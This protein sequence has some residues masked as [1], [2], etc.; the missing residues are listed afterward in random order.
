[1]HPDPSARQ[2]ALITALALLVVY[3]ITA[4]PALTFWDASEFAAAI[5]T[6]GIPHPPGTP[7]YVALGSTLW[8]LAPG[9]TPV[10]AGTLLS[11][12]ATASACGL[13][14]WIAA[15]CT[16]DRPAAVVAGLCAGLMGT[17]WMN[18]TETEVYAVSLLSV[19]LQ[20]S[21]AWRA[22]QH[23]DDRARML[24]IYLAA[25]SLPLHLSALVATPAAMLLACTDRDGRVR[26]NALS[27]GGL[28]ILAT[29]LL[30]RAAYW[31]ALVSIGAAVVITRGP[32]VTRRH[33]ASSVPPFRRRLAW[34]RPAALLTLLGWSAIA[35]LLVRARHSP[36]L[37]QGD[38][39]TVAKLF[40]VITRAQYD[41]AGIWPRRA[42]PWIQ[43]GNIGQYADWQVALSLWN[44]VT[45]S[46]WRTPFTVVAGCLGVV[47]AQSHW[48][49]HPVTA[50]AAL[51]LALLATLGVCTQLNLYAGPSY[52]AGVLPIDALHEARERDYFYAL[53]F[54][55]WG[56]WIGIGA[57]VLAKR[58]PWPR[59]TAFAVP[60]LMAV[61]S[62]SAVARDALPDR[63]IVGVMAAELL[64]DV[65]QR[66]LLFTAGDNDSY[67]LWYAQAVDSTRTDVQIVV[68]SLL[69]AN[70]YFRERV[71]AL[72]GVTPDT[73][74]A[75]SSSARAIALARAQL[76]SG[77][78]IA[79]TALVDA[80]FRT[81]LGAQAGVVCWQRVGMIDL[82][83]RGTVCP[84]RVHVARSL[85]SAERLR[86]V[87]FPVA[88]QSPDGMVRAFQRAA[89]CP[90][91]AVTVAL[92]GAPAPDS[93]SRALLDITCNLR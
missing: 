86:S 72:A 48:R 75:R 64:H 9:L 1:M 49:S 74:R 93:A 25:L 12:M 24:L 50:R 31:A 21:I 20:L 88:R 73:I 43:L 69:P 68:T 59:L 3:V 42:P 63:R 54:W 70:W 34:L 87:A 40:D 81:E 11:A 13:V 65:P 19:A 84:P 67:P 79:V 30:S 23:N 76:E 91:L 35:I 14:A 44:D 15:Q 38:P 83:H 82:G 60:L 47:G 57:W 7:L 80:A 10:Q 53:A 78:R 18:A 51:I 37:N 8:H 27:E 52:G 5:G 6:F 39:D 29:I 55:C 22:H 4:A 17:V 56:V 2:S 66:G 41:V 58:T 26:W 62:W 33:P 46:W 16:P 92:T 32:A 45:P 36:Y 28:L 85:E 61:G 90:Q 89:R 77:G 71:A